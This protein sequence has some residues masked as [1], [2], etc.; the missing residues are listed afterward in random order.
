[1]KLGKS[2][3]FTLHATLKSCRP[4]TFVVTPVGINDQMVVDVEPMCECPCAE[5]GDGAEREDRSVGIFN[6]GLVSLSSS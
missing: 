2:V 4:E 5:E 3:K 6:N 1:M